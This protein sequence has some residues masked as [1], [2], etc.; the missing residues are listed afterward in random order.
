MSNL[1]TEHLRA[2]PEFAS[3]DATIVSRLAATGEVFELPADTVLYEQ[4]STPDRFYILIEGKI[5]LTGRSSDGRSTVVDVLMPV[6]QFALAALLSGGEHLMGAVTLTP[7]RVLGIPAATLNRMLGE[8]PCL[9][10]AMLASMSR[11]YRTLVRQVKD[12]K[13]RTSTQRLGCYLLALSDEHHATSFRLPYDKR[14]IAERLGMTR[15]N[16]S[17][18]FAALRAYGV[19]TRGAAIKLDNVARLAAYAL[20]DRPVAAEAAE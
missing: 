8:D 1:Y 19:E 2:L 6:D 5:G 17:R 4:G 13:L 7:S 10:R 3:V 12:L 11:H 16:L 15:E 9:T 14:I 20:P 18:A